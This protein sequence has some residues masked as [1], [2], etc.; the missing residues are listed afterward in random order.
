MFDLKEN[1][2]YLLNTKFHSNNVNKSVL[3][4]MVSNIQRA[5]RNLYV[6]TWV[7]KGVGK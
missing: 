5:A 3:N 7:V 1:F 2:Q 4:W 6:G